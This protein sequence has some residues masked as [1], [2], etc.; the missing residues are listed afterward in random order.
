[1]ADTGWGIDYNLTL[2]CIRNA[3]NVKMEMLCILGKDDLI[4]R[5]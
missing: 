4:I 3:K 5:S 2:A 1:M